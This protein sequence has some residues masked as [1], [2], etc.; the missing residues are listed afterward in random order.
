M[1]GHVIWWLNMR[2]LNACHN[3][4]KN[5][6]NMNS[7]RRNPYY[8]HIVYVFTRC[9]PPSP[10]PHFTT[11]Q[12]AAALSATATNCDIATTSTCH[13][14]HCSNIY[15]IEF[16]WSPVRT[17]RTPLTPSHVAQ[18][19][20]AYFLCVSVYNCLVL[21]ACLSCPHIVH[22]W[23]TRRWYDTRG[24]CTICGGYVVHIVCSAWCFTGCVLLSYAKYMYYVH[25]HALPHTHT[26]TAHGQPFHMYIRCECI[27]REF[28]FKDY[29]FN[30]RVYIALHDPPPPAKNPGWIFIYFCLPIQPRQI[31]T[32][33][34]NTFC[35]HARLAWWVVP[36]MIVY[37]CVIEKELICGLN[38]DG[39]NAK[40]A[41]I[42]AVWRYSIWWLYM[43][44]FPFLIGYSLYFI[45]RFLPGD[46]KMYI[47]S[48]YSVNCIRIGKYIKRT[49]FHHNKQ[50]Q[51][52][53][54]F[55]NRTKSTRL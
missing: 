23:M 20:H 37:F 6:R 33:I 1:V 25:I 48:L 54:H 49:R 40:S 24:V 31:D 35:V 17:A 22:M 42:H 41:H 28:V 39:W 50:Q 53:T 34:G 36:V 51:N 55:I 8:V 44:I 10:P 16:L 2:L 12:H 4:N 5:N 30:T 26:Q 7:S 45:I 46:T 3:N 47:L 32:L 13:Y 14:E 52:H 29:P 38:Y 27:I 21:F 9:L 43:Y 11:Q 18:L 19:Q 15:D